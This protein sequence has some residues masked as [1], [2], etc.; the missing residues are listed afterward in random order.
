[1]YSAVKYRLIDGKIL[2]VVQTTHAADL[3]ANHRPETEGM[4]TPP[5]D[6]PVWG[7]QQQWRV[8]DGQLVT[9]A[10]RQE[11]LEEAFNAKQPPTTRN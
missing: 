9:V 11:T 3:L 6:H 5:P 7:A 8:L 4:L 10:E 1:M 2:G